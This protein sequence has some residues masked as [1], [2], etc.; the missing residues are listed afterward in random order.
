MNETRASKTL[1]KVERMN[2]ALRHEE[3]DRV[4]VGEFFWG[5]FLKRWRRELGL[6]DDTD[7]YQ[8]YD[9]DWIVTT[10][11]MDPHIKPF[12]TLR[13]T[14]EEVV[15]RTGF[16]GVVRK[17]FDLPMPEAV[18]W[19][20]D[21]IEK[22][23]AFEFDPPDDPRRFFEGGDNQ[24]AGVG[25]GFARNSPPWLDTVKSLRKDYALYGSMIETSECLTRMI[26]QMNTLMWVGEY[27]E[28]LGQQILRIGD[29][30]YQC[31]KAEIEAA[32]GLLDGMV[33]WGD[34]AYSAN[35]FFAPE[36]WRTYFRPG[37]EK[38][39][40]LCHR[41][42]LPVIY[43]G[44]G[45]VKAILPDFIEMKLDAYNPLEAKA[46]LDVVALRRQYGHS[47][48]FCGNGNIQVWEAGQEEAL[49]REVLRKLNAAKGGGFIFQSDHSVSSGVSG[50]TYDFIVNLVREFG[51]YPLE[52]GEYDEQM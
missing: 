41:H 15:V 45:N 29:F 33:I 13:E 27:P 50:H 32:E 4:P 20:T 24:I 5:S 3:P 25:D 22:L 9:L 1:A 21:T 42:S 37:V 26:G 36:Y 35:M 16:G 52:L 18:S 23:E 44:C 30:Y 51:Q 43:H 7:P 31:C 28:R 48:A 47:I 19:E 10:P 40:A 38:M 34:V 39:I 8:Y 2:K 14:N 46:G 49:R 17:R 11:N 6:P 12:E